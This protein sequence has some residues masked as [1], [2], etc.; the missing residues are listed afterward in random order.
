MGRI[1]D[2][3]LNRPDAHAVSVGGLQKA[4]IAEGD[5][6]SHPFTGK[7]EFI[8]ARFQDLGRNR[9]VMGALRL[10]FDKDGNLCSVD[11]EAPA[12]IDVALSELETEFLPISLGLEGK[13]VFRAVG[14]LIG[15]RPLGAGVI[16]EMDVIGEKDASFF[17]SGEEGEQAEAKEEGNESHG[18]ILRATP[19]K[20]GPLTE[21]RSPG[22][23]VFR[24]RSGASY[25]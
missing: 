23:L 2:L 15:L 22:F 25:R 8:G 9:V 7:A 5:V 4:D 1:E 6:V 14:R 11:S 18:F 19:I 24:L 20:K 12:V 10:L 13:G 17:L 3:N 16:A 21:V